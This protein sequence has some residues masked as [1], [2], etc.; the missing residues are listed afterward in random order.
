MDVV[1][2]CPKCGKAASLSPSDLGTRI[3]CP[4]CHRSFL[5]DPATVGEGL[6]IEAGLLARI[7]EDAS[8]QS[9][10]LKSI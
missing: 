1:I 10:T 3:I 4:K 7:A 8:R 2:K 5:A 9:A 6:S